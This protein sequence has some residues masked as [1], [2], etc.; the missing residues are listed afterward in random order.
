MYNLHQSGFPSIHNALRMFFDLEVQYRGK[1]T[2]RCYMPE[3]QNFHITDLIN[4]VKRGYI[5]I[6]Q[7][8]RDFIWS[9]E[10]AAS[11]MDSI[12]K[13]YPIGTMILWNCGILTV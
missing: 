13:G 8:Q 2:W 12:L 9:K 3:H 5:K 4:D 11:L 1:I 7:F 6:P 10:K